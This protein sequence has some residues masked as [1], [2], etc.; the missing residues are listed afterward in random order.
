MNLDYLPRDAFGHILEQ[1]N[2]VTGVKGFI[3]DCDILYIAKY[4]ASLAGT[5]KVIASHVPLDQK[6]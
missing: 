5:C 3:N 6:R 2:H 1:L 4:A